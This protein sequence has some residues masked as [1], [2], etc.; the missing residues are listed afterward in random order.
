MSYESFMDGTFASIKDYILKRLEE[1]CE[2]VFKGLEDYLSLKD[3][4]LIK[5]NMIVRTSEGGMIDR[6]YRVNKEGNLEGIT[7][8]PYPGPEDV[9]EPE[10]VFDGKQNRDGWTL[11]HF[12]QLRFLLKDS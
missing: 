1:G 4:K 7:R 2:L 11:N 8:G 6:H 3:E 12:S 5:E 10:Q 9:F